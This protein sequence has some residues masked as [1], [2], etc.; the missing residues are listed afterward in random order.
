MSDKI[1]TVSEITKKIKQLLEPN[2]PSLWI[3]GELSN[4]YQ[5]VSG[6]CYFTL[7]DQHA[8]IKG[9]MFRT[10]ASSLRFKPADG[11]QVR[12]LGSIRVYEPD[13][14]YQFYT[15]QMEQ[16]GLGQL[17]LA[18]EQLKAKLQ[19]EGL[20]S[21]EYKKPLPKYP[22]R[23]GIVTSET[24]AVI[25][26]IVTII[27]RRYP[28]VRLLLYPARVQGDGA[29]QDIVR[30]IHAFQ[31]MHP[32]KRPDVLII[33]RGGGSIE[34]LWP[35]NE[36][37]VARAIFRCDIPI[38]SAVGHEVD[39]TISDFV[40]DVRAPTPS[41]AAELAVPDQ[42]AIRQNLETSTDRLTTEM[43]RILQLHDLRMKRLSASNLFRPL[44]VIQNLQIAMDHF[45][46]KLSHG[47]M[48]N[49]SLTKN[50]LGELRSRFIMHGPRMTLLQHQNKLH[51]L[52]Q[53]LRQHMAQILES[54]RSK[55]ES[56]R[57]RFTRCDLTRFRRTLELIDARIRGHDPR[58]IL[59]RGYAI[60]L[61]TDGTIVTSAHDVTIQEDV[62]VEL[63][64]GDIRCNVKERNLK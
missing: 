12:L 23:I 27:S 8:K 54:E 33:G 20:F 2:F 7:K 35:F 16:S 47:S 45:A 46:S 15:Q 11:M 32:A 25:R 18:F 61:K 63:G 59:S 53:Q 41:A 29:A 3:E 49:V 38:I 4:F 51:L 34:D 48:R 50:R 57:R 42:Q 26:D 55:M 44:Q 62:V 56:V 52:K 13:G 40:A 58:G 60:C 37:I 6:H 36:E 14:S 31:R 24:G 1:Y 17:H 9:V 64:K 22:S 30:G 10:H 28:I 43:R 19:M 39:F 5:H 21:G